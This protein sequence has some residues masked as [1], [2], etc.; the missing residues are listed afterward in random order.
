ME[1]TLGIE[2]EGEG[3]ESPISSLSDSYD[4]E[5]EDPNDKKGEVQSTSRPRLRYGRLC[6]LLSLVCLQIETQA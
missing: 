1:V 3:A 2:E 6:A 4:E 5:D